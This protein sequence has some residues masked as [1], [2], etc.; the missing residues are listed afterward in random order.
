MTT[1]PYDVIKWRA[2]RCLLGRETGVLNIGEDNKRSGT[3]NP[4]KTTILV[5]T[6]STVKNIATV[7]RRKSRVWLS[8]AASA[9]TTVARADMLCARIAFH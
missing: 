2:S 8:Q 5:I 4:A 7:R 1:K 3:N 6:T 9:T